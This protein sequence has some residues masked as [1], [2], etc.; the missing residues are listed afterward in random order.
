MRNIYLFNKIADSLFFYL[1][2]CTIKDYLWKCTTEYIVL[3]NAEE[4]A[5]YIVK[6]LIVSGEIEDIKDRT[7]YI[8]IDK[9]WK[10]LR[11]MIATCLVAKE[12]GKYKE[13]VD[14]CCNLLI[15]GEKNSARHN[16]NENGPVF[17]SKYEIKNYL[18]D[19]AYDIIAKASNNSIDGMCYIINRFYMFKFTIDMLKNNI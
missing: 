1:P 13:Y 7:Y 4:V 14:V 19:F 10:M 3:D 8:K 9:A 5:T 17:V 11:E 16:I 18:L 2:D 12:K 15:F 6:N